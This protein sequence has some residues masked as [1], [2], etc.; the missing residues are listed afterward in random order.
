MPNS[1]LVRSDNPISINVRTENEMY[2]AGL[3]DTTTLNF[4]STTLTKMGNSYDLYLARLFYQPLSNSL[5][6]ADLT[7]FYPNP[8]NGVV[9]F[10]TLQTNYD[11]KLFNAL[12]QCVKTGSLTSN[13]ILDISEVQVGVYSM[14]LADVEGNIITKKLIKQ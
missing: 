14:V 2:I 7:L 12:G 6:D 3:F 1:S 8:T 11:Y 9:H 4:G 13:D 5:F 10:D